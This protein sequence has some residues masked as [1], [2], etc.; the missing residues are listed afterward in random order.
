LK[1]G[2]PFIGLSSAFVKAGALMA[3]SCDYTDIGIQAAE[4]AK[5]ILD[6]EN[7]KDIPIAVPR[8][9]LLCINMR[10]AKHIGLNIPTSIIELADEVIR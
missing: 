3:L 8:K 2:V 10:T 1:T 4:T 5:R 7:P 6:G 9:V